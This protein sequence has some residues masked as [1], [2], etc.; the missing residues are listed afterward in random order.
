[1]AVI[2]ISRQFGAGGRTLGMRVAKKIGYRFADH[3]L[4]EKVSRELGISDEWINVTEREGHGQDSLVSSRAIAKILGRL[5]GGAESADDLDAKVRNSFSHFIPEIAAGG[6]VVF[7]GRGSQ[8]YCQDCENIL[9]IFLVAPV[10][11][12]EDFLVQNHNLT[13]SEARRTIKDWD[14]NRSAFLKKITDR[15]PDDPSL[16]DLCLNTSH[17]SMDR[18]ESLICELAQMRTPE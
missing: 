10:S 5:R 7:V 14:K 18:A 1:M 11:W 13:H 3:E 17:I 12:R 9:R 4:M 6:R 2:C 16:Y 15:N 8:F